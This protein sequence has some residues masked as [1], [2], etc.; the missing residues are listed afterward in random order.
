[1]IW[2]QD[3]GGGGG[4]IITDETTLS[5]I[6]IIITIIWYYDNLFSLLIHSF[7]Q[8]LIKKWKKKFSPYT[9]VSKA[10]VKLKAI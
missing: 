3:P 7:I 9:Y 6:I 1:M 8:R 5:I 2:L 10:L 4:S